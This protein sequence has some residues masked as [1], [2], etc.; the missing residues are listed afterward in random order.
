AGA[1]VDPQWVSQFDNASFLFNFTLHASDR[2]A[3]PKR[4]K[5]NSAIPLL[6]PCCYENGP[7]KDFKN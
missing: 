5:A 6:F 1:R 2:I 3:H 7:A 4:H